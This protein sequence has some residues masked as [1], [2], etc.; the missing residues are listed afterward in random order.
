MKTV[1]HSCL[2][3][4]ETAY[5]IV[6][7]ID[8]FRASNTILMLLSRGA[9]SIIPVATIQEAFA[10]K[11]KHPECLLAGERGG[12][13]V[14]GFDMGNS[15]H[16]ASG[17]DLKGKEV[18]FTTSAGTQGII[19]A[20]H[21]ERILIGSFANANALASMLSD[22]SPPLVT[23]LAVGTEGISKAAEDELCA[24]YLKGMLEDVPQ[25]F[26]AMKNEIMQGEGA[27]R[28]RNLGQELDFSYCLATDLFDSV[29]EV[30][31]KKGSMRI[32]AE[33]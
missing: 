14:A 33:R 19:R 4:A 9:A 3:G 25:D 12:V 21:A 7:M 6:V 24:L 16:E 13:K 11:E 15:P 32:Q 1:I 2:T 26:H 27:Q 22:V 20:G 23:C 5:G 28:L 8:V 30:I 29:P 18:V 10:L 17:M 31:R